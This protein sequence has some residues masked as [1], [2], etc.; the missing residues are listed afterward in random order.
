M[1]IISMK[2][3]YVTR[4]VLLTAILLTAFSS[5]IFGQEVSG[6]INGSV[7]DPNGAA[8]SGAS[9]TLTDPKRQ[10]NSR[11]VT[12]NDDGQFSAPNLEPGFY[13]VTVEAQNFK[14]HVESGV[15]LDVSERRS[16]DITL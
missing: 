9:V 8:V 16:V 7:K 10:S 4:L 14:K 3:I 5:T 15:K 12:T 2:R 11:T 13:D 1:R 6:T